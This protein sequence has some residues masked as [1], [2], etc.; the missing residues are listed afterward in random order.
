MV[1]FL[2]EPATGNT[3]NHIFKLSLRMIAVSTD[4]R[5]GQDENLVQDM[6]LIESNGRV[7]KLAL[8]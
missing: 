4:Q 6:N 2:N 1:S 8:Y 5:N 7:E 3:N